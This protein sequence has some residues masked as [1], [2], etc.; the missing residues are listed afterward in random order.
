MRAAL[1]LWLSKGFHPMPLLLM[2]R[3]SKSDF[4]CGCCS[5]LPWETWRNQSFTWKLITPCVKIKIYWSES[6]D[7]LSPFLFYCSQDCLRINH[8]PTKANSARQCRWH[9]KM[10]KVY[11]NK[12]FTILA[13]PACIFRKAANLPQLNTKSGV[14]LRTCLLKN[15]VRLSRIATAKT[16]QCHLA[17]IRGKNILK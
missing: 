10:T 1:E 6:W 11:T 9:S 15:S 12:L 8:I 3:S 14:K 5:A 13:P 17:R 4:L 2:P 7:P 16:I